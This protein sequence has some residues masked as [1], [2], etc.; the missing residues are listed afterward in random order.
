MC[1]SL[2]I[3]YGVLRV[4]AFLNVNDKVNTQKR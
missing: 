4:M 3:M 1:Y 2:R